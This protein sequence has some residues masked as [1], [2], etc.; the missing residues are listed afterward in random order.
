MNE[1]NKLAMVSW[2]AKAMANPPIPKL[3]INEVILTSKVNLSVTKKAKMMMTIF[4][5]SFKNRIKSRFKCG[6]LLP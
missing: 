5:N 4:D 6:F 1:P 3:A 2:A